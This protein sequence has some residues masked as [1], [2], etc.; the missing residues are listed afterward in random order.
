MFVSFFFLLTL[1]AQHLSVKLT[2][3]QGSI[4]FDIKRFLMHPRL[5]VTDNLNAVLEYDNAKASSD[6]LGSEW[7]MQ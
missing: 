3:M 5:L 2:V 4:F 7:D 6:A 1:L